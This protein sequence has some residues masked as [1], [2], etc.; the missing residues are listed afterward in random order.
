MKRESTASFTTARAAQHDAVL[1]LQAE[2]APREQLRL[3]GGEE[4]LHCALRAI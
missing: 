1:K 3:L 2:D 4:P